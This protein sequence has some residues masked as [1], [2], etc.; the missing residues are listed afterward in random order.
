MKEFNYLSDN[1][2][3][4]LSYLQSI[5][6]ILDLRNSLRNSKYSYVYDNKNINYKKRKPLLI[7]LRF[8]YYVIRRIFVLYLPNF[9]EIIFRI[10]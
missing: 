10:K 2:Y 5:M 6:Q 1:N 4:F 9:S 7:P 3:N 8:T